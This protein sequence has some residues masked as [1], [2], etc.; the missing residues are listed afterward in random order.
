MSNELKTESQYHNAAH[1][2][3]SQS[4]VNANTNGN[5]EYNAYQGTGG[6]V[7]RAITPGGNPMDSSQP[8][9]PVYHRRFANPAPLGLMAYVEIEPRSFMVSF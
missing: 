9:F 8:A 7:H 2:A 6:P 1:G 3:A 5:G 4:T